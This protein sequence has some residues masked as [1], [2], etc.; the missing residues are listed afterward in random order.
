MDTIEPMLSTLDNRRICRLLAITSYEEVGNWLAA[1]DTSDLP[2][3][4]LPHAHYELWS[5]EVCADSAWLV[6]PFR[7]SNQQFRAVN[8]NV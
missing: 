8:Y 5:A 3:R 4:A 1:I 6:F 7:K 2:C